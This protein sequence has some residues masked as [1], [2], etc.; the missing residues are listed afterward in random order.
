MRAFVC[1]FQCG[2]SPLSLKL[3][4]HLSL[5]WQE[6]SVFYLAVDPVE[7]IVTVNRKENAVIVIAK[8]KYTFRV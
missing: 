8:A 3:E 5:V 7:P 4:D 6:A 1:G 2:A